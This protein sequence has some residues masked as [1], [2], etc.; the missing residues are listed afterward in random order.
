M[1][2]NTDIELHDLETIE[3][4]LCTDEAVQSEVDDDSLHT[5][6][7]AFLIG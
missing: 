4:N 6:A 7:N 1:D 5:S 3:S 2:T